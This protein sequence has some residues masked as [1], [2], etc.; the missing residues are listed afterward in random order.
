MVEGSFQ[1]SQAV[2]QTKVMACLQVLARGN[3][4]RDIYHMSFISVPTAQ[5][6]FHSFCRHFA[7][8]M[9]HEHIYLPTGDYQTKVMSEYERLGFTG[10]IG[11]TDVTHLAWGCCPYN[12]ARSFTGKEGYPTIAYQVT[13]DHTK[14]ALA[15]TPGFTGATND[16]T[17]IRFDKAVT[18]IRT[19]PIYTERTYNLYD[20]DGATRQEKGCYLLVNNGY[21]KWNTLMAPTKYA[22]EKGDTVFSN[23]LESSRKDVECYFGIVKGRFRINKLAIPYHKKEDIDNVFFTCC[24]LHNMLHSYDNK[25]EMGEEPNWAGSAGLHNAWE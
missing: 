15:V 5:A 6:T 11:S 16:K 4:F 2:N 13:V 9:Y 19:D 1:K 24:I 8:E 25:G 3:V 10:A 20:A 17:I 14:R 23:R 22:I 7:R 12:Q 21:H 18:R